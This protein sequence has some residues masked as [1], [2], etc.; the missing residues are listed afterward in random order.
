MGYKIMEEEGRKIKREK[1]KEA[2]KEEE[3]KQDK[4]R[5]LFSGGVAEETGRDG[6]TSPP[7]N[8]KT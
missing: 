2:R 6:Q 5:S 4:K 3:E 1:E 8:T 7:R